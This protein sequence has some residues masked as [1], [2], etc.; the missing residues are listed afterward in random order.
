MS[1]TPAFSRV[2]YVTAAAN[3]RWFIPTTGYGD[4]PDSGTMAQQLDQCELMVSTDA[5]ES[6]R[7]IGKAVQAGTLADW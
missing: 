6:D 4:N 5:G 7:E 3:D 1:R 2:L